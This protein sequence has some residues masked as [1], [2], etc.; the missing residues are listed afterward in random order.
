MRTLV[1]LS[2]VAVLSACGGPA[3]RPDGGFGGGFGGGLGGGL[4]GGAGG[5]AGGGTGGGAAGG[6]AGGGGGAIDAGLDDGTLVLRQRLVGM[7]RQRGAWQES[8]HRLV[9]LPAGVSSSL[10]AMTTI[11]FEGDA[12]VVESLPVTGALSSGVVEA[13][14]MR[15][16]EAVAIVRQYRPQALDVVRFS[17]SATGVTAQKLSAATPLPYDGY[18]FGDLYASGAGFAASRGNDVVTLSLGGNAVSWS[19]QPGQLFAGN[20]SALVEDAPRG[21]LLAFGHEAYDVMNMRI[22]FKQELQ[23]FG[24]P[25]GPWA[26]ISLGGEL[27]VAELYPSPGAGWAAWDSALQ[28]L[29][30][31]AN[32]QGMCGGIPCLKRPLFV[33]NLATN[34][35]TKL[36]DHYNGAYRQPAWATDPA[37][38]RIIDGTGGQLEIAE[39]RATPAQPDFRP[40]PLDGTWFEAGRYASSAPAA[41]MLANGRVVAVMGTRFV[42]LDPSASPPR[43]VSFG[44]AT[45]PSSGTTSAPSLVEDPSTGTIYVAGL[46][47]LY[48]LSA[49]GKTLTPV[50]ASGA[51]AER[52]RPGVA[53]SGRELIV[54][55]GSTSAGLLDEIHAFHLDQRTW[56]RLGTLPVGL[57]DASV[58]RGSRD[59]ELL[60]V[61]RTKVGDDYPLTAVYALDVGTQ[62]VTALTNDGAPPANA[63]MIA[64]LGSGFVV[65]ESGDTVD[66]SEPSLFRAKRI[67]STVKWERVAL[68]EVDEALV[69]HAGVGLG[70]RSALFV[71]RGVWEVRLDP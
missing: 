12:G 55:G 13:W 50:T 9:A 20:G 7:A 46:A 22:V 2:A 69:G 29:Y 49:D 64:P 6:G 51:P 42:S 18:I 67:G 30:V 66:G 36:V 10:G 39:L 61:G 71:G 54:A 4:G 48:A 38:H 60:I 19:S 33:A 31:T 68:P 3:V 21:R 52:W 53:V 17:F 27:P 44:T 11:R 23:Q 15:G 65:M 56:R 32:E 63:W 14:G 34:Q 70:T 8:Q 41:T 28:H 16:D 25:A 59:G 37:T 40:L 35:W 62:Q 57:F 45:L 5:G 47:Q 24:L 43:W 1:L 26:T 58:R